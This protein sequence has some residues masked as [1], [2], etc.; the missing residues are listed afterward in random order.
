MQ[1]FFNIV[2]AFKEYVVLALLTILSLVLL[3]LNDNPQIRTIRAYTVGFVGFLQS[4]TSIIPNPFALEKENEILREQNV[5]LTDE[6]SRLRE[7]KL[8]ND[9][10]RAMLELKEHSSYHL[11]AA[12]VVGKTLDLLRNTITLNVGDHDGVK[13]NMPV[14]SETGLVGRIIATSRNYSVGQLMMNKEFRASAKIQRSRVVGIIAWDGGEYLGLRNV[15]KTQDIMVGDVVMTS[16]YSNV[17]PRD[18]K[19]GIVTNI[20]EHEGGLFREIR[21]KPSADLLTIEHVFV[22]AA[23]PETERTRIDSK[24]PR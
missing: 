24:E 6:V 19:I 14:V 15:A 10:L 23:V 17:F 11:V 2:R 13:P 20:S 9:R 1:R 12:D 16:E 18:L 5:G 8:E 4:A 21:V 3:S 22:L 7:A